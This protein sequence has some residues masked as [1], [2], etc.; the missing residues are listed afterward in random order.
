MDTK[1]H[2][3]TIQSRTHALISGVEKVVDSTN[4]QI[5]IV[6][7]DGGLCIKG[8]DL[9]I[10]SFSVND[11]NLSFEGVVDRL[12]YIGKKTPLLKRLFK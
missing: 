11:G 10:N 7:V 9:K 4:S 1:K 12:E 6:T 2:S 5:N 3:I 8:T